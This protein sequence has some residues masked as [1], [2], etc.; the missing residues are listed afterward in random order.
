MK[1]KKMIIVAFLLAIFSFKAQSQSPF[2]SYEMKYYNANFDINIILK[3]NTYQLFV[4][5]LCLENPETTGG[6]VITEKK[7]YDFIES[8]N[9][10]KLKYA[11]LIAAAKEG[12]MTR[13]GESIRVF[14]TVDIFFNLGKYV[15]KDISIDYNFKVIKN[16]D[17]NSYLLIVKADKFSIVFSTPEEIDAFMLA[18]ES[19]K[20]NNYVIEHE[21]LGYLKTFVDTG[22]EKHSLS[23]SGVFSKLSLGLKMDYNTYLGDKIKSSKL[24]LEY[25]PI[26]Y[27]STLNQGLGIGVFAILPI[28]RFSIQPEISY[29]QAKVLSILNFYDMH[30]QQIQT[31]YS[32]VQRNINVPIVIGYSVFQKKKTNVALHVGPVFTFDLNS[33]PSLDAFGTFGVVSS[34]D[35]LYDV[36]FFNIGLESG[37]VCEFSTFTVGAKYRMIQNPYH[38]MLNNNQIGSFGANN[39]VFSVGFKLFHAKKQN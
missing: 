39:F 33:K 25:S 17:V 6:F 23:K 2:S 10:A 4:D 35:L 1:I 37:V 22:K 24:I 26:N 36:D 5:A 27:S 8:L 7:Y 16:A 3:G 11:D 21:D 18:V 14:G 31:Q 30:L 38:T 19:K 34:D 13:G 15:V 9:L 20:V 32:V 28:Q 29:S 12:K